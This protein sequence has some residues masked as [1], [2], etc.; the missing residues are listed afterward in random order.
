MYGCLN[1]RLKHHKP[2]SSIHATFKKMPASRRVIKIVTSHILKL[3]SQQSCSSH[4]KFIE[5]AI[6]VAFP[7]FTTSTVHNVY[8]QVLHCLRTNRILAQRR[9]IAGQAVTQ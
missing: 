5:E 4:P 3:M 1:L 8:D 2:Y 9:V 6:S 7:A